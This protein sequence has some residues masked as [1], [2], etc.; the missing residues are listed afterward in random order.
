[1]FTSTIGREERRR[2]DRA[3]EE[4]IDLPK[5][6]LK[7]FYPKLEHAVGLLRDR[8]GVTQGQQLARILDE[9]V[10]TWPEDWEVIWL[11]RPFFDLYLPKFPLIEKL[12]PRARISV[13]ALGVLEFPRQE[14]T[15]LDASLY[16][17]M[18]ALWNALQGRV[19]LES[20]QEIYQN[21]QEYK[22]QAAMRRATVRAAFALL[23]GYLNGLAGDITVVRAGGLTEKEII[24]LIEW[25][26][27]KGKPRV[28][29]LRQKISEYPRI[30]LGVEEPPLTEDSCPVLKEVLD[31]VAEFRHAF[32]HPTPIAPPAS[33][34][35]QDRESIHF[36]IGDDEV[37]NMCDSVISLIQ[38]VASLVGPEYG[39]V[40]DWLFERDESGLFPAT[41][42]L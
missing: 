5:N 29:T 28:L 19:R 4:L 36:Q 10:E 1:M 12:P 32:V 24:K 30:A 40:E 26:E 37:A 15:I 34:A 2:I 13:D 25:N 14:V 11:F 9:I 27:E 6:E 20:H 7:T 22:T 16:E 3:I 18:A 31:A 21:Q 23:E 38:T 17:D 33:H 39:A 42:F 8:Y 35:I 41:A